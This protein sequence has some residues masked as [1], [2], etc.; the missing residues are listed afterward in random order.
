[1]TFDQA[2]E[3]F[4]NV[5]AATDVVALGITEHMPWEAL[6]LKELLESVPI[7]TRKR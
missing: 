5:S 4:S 7:L 6:N 3:I 2:R 1:M